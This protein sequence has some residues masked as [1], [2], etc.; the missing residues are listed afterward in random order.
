MLG[1]YPAFYNMMEGVKRMMEDMMNDNVF[2]PIPMLRSRM[3]SDV[4]EFDDHYKVEVEIPGFDKE[5]INL[6]YSNGFLVIKADRNLENK[7]EDTKAKYL[8]KEREITSLTRTLKVPNVDEDKITASL[9]NGV[10]EVILPKK[11]V[12]TN[13]QIPIS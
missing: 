1:N 11:E 12:Q 3:R 13:K 8:Y 4:I 5:E 10:L 6:S 2:E 9:K 7:V